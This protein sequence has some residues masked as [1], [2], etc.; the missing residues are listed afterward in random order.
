MVKSALEQNNMGIG[1]GWMG[2]CEIHSLREK[3]SVAI[4][5]EVVSKD[6]KELI[7]KKGLYSGKRRVYRNYPEHQGV[8]CR[9]EAAYK[10]GIHQKRSGR[11]S[12]RPKIRRSR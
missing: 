3:V 1:G 8:I 11:M 7:S 2:I 9:P 5:A 10:A 4:P 12:C 6:R